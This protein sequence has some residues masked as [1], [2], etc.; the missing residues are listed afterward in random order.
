[1]IRKM[2]KADLGRTR[3]GT[4][5]TNVCKVNSYSNR[6]RAEI[7]RNLIK[8]AEAYGQAHYENVEE[9]KVTRLELALMRAAR[10]WAKCQAAEH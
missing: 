1:M 6:K 9:V 10:A 4:W 2:T 3:G 5:G 7:K 8:A